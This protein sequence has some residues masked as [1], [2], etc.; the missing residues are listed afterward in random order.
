M[1]TLKSSLLLI[2]MSIT[3]I[4]H[5][6]SWGE[7]I[8]PNANFLDCDKLQWNEKP[9]CEAAEKN[10]K[11]TLKENQI[12]LIN[13]ELIK[14]IDNLIVP[15]RIDTGHSC[16]K[17]RWL[18]SNFSQIKTEDNI[19]FDASELKLSEPVIVDITIPV[20]AYYKLNFKDRLSQK[21]DI[22]FDSGCEKLAEDNWFLSGSANTTAKLSIIISLEPKLTQDGENFIITITPKVDAE[23]LVSEPSVNLAEHGKEDLFTLTAS[24]WSGVSSLFKANYE[25]WIEGDSEEAFN[26]IGRE[27]E[28][29]GTDIILFTPIGDSVYDE[30]SERMASTAYSVYDNQKDAVEIE[31]ET[32]LSEMLGLDSNGETKYEVPLELP[33]QYQAALLSSILSTII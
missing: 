24:I 27:F 12:S 10:F 1:K 20:E 23:L 7:F 25:A 17:K 33:S 3:Q 16:T 28:E 32:Q 15:Q 30:V 18:K 4:S 9:I 13:G 31:I 21:W 2:S 22:G 5:G 19:D 26:I 8:D 29:I 6:L 14:R 11:Q